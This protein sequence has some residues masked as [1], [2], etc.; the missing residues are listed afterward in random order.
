V[1]VT[2][3]KRVAVLAGA[4]LVAGALIVPLAVY[5]RSPGRVFVG[6]ACDSRHPSAR[7]VSLGGPLCAVVL[8]DQPLVSHAVIDVEVSRR[9]ESGAWRGVATIAWRAEA[10]DDE[11][12]FRAPHLDRLIGDRPGTYRIAFAREGHPIA[13]A[14]FTASPK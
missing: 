2:T 12:V 10:H 4:A 6:A 14:T 9:D 8:L 3:K 1:A 5:L 7:A 13:D 11:I